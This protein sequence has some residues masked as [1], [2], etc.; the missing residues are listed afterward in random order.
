[1]ITFEQQTRTI[2]ENLEAEN[3]PE[4]EFDLAEYYRDVEAQEE[5]RLDTPELDDI[6][7]VAVVDGLL[8]QEKYDELQNATGDERYR[9]KE[10]IFGNLNPRDLRKGFVERSQLNNTLSSERFQNATMT[11][12]EALRMTKPQKLPKG[13]YSVVIEHGGLNLTPWLRVKE[14]LDTFMDPDGERS[15]DVSAAAGGA[16]LVNDAEKEK[17]AS[18]IADYTRKDEIKYESDLMDAAVEHWLREHDLEDIIE[19]SEIVEGTARGETV[20]GVPY[21]MRLY[22]LQA[23]KADGRLPATMPNVIVSL[24]APMD[25]TR[26]MR[27]GI[28]TAYKDRPDTEDPLDMIHQVVHLEPGDRVGSISHHPVS[29][30]QLLITKEAFLEDGVIVEEGAYKSDALINNPGVR[31]SEICKVV[32]GAERLREHA[33]EKLTQLQ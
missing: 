14:G 23:A 7:A 1:M 3:I 24:N 27:R 9:L 20:S 4:N 18:Y 8:T 29:K 5:R 12:A 13:H 17:A 15:A 2:P 19:Q 32:S 22:D 11:A 21:W 16:R 6:L 31:F 26:Q 25:A 30:G 33:Q 28:K 10:E